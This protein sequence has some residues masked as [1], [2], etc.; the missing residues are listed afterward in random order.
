MNTCF[1]VILIIRSMLRLIGLSDYRLMYQ[2]TDE[3]I[4]SN[5]VVCIFNEKYDT[6][7]ST[8]FLFL[9]QKLMND[10]LAYFKNKL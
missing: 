5:V 6:N 4:S 2:Y 7:D 1:H 3:N 8:W 10:K 9:K